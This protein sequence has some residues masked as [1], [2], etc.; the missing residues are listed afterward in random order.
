MTIRR[1]IPN[2][3]ADDLGKSRE[4]YAGFL[5]FDV[6]MD[7]P[8]FT[9]FASPSNRTAQITVADRAK[10]GL[11][12]GISEAH[13]SVEVEDVDKLHAEAVSR[14]LEVVYPLT[15]EPWDVRRFFVRDPD[16]RVINVLM[17]L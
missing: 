16:G 2:L 4:F 7:E 11:D 13:I 17:H 8:G 6:A 1:A 14:G 12:R 15:D 5:G 3:L 10:P 9:M